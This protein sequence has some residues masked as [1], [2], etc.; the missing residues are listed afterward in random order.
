MNDPIDRLLRED[1]A[2]AIA[3]EAFT[4]RVMAALPPPA[5]S[6]APSWF[7]PLL[8]LGS[9]ALGALLA[10]ALAPA[11]ISLVQGFQDLVQM[12]GLTQPAIAGLAISVA[13]LVS[14]VIFATSAD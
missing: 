14:A 12:R 3:D 7:M 1:A 13:M 2:R 9:A 8:I 6:T 4:L 5:A 11:G 10:V